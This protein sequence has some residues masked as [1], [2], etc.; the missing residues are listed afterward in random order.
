MLVEVYYEIK[1]SS[2]LPEIIPLKANLRSAK[3]VAV[4]HF[5][6]MEHRTT[7]EVTFDDG[8]T[9]RW[10]ISPLT[11][12]QKQSKPPQI[13]KGKKF[14]NLEYEVWPGHREKP[15]WAEERLVEVGSEE[16]FRSEILNAMNDLEKKVDSDVEK[17]PKGTPL[18]VPQSMDNAKKKV[19]SIAFRNLI[20]EINKDWKKESRPLEKL[21]PEILAIKDALE[22]MKL[23]REEFGEEMNEVRKGLRVL[24]IKCSR[25]IGDINRLEKT[26][27]LS[28]LHSELHSEVLAIKEALELIRLARE[29]FGE[30]INEIGKDLDLKGEKE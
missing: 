2:G 16:D 10:T 28:K 23:A 27:S 24:W 3:E 19:L 25:V 29:E 17:D 30:E 22:L 6:K 5:M 7:V 20:G 14:A 1:K 26:E 18:D 11:D 4:D 8:G 15:R 21:R 13:R 9:K 12:F